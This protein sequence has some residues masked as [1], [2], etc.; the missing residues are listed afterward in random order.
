[1]LRQDEWPSLRELLE[2]AL[3]G[4]RAHIGGLL[5]LLACFWQT[6]LGFVLF[7]P[8]VRSARH[9][10]RELFPVNSRRR[11]RDPEIERIQ[12]GR[13]WSAAISSFLIL[14]AYGTAEDWQQAQ[15]QFGLRLLITPW[16]LLL[17][18]PAVVGLLFRLA[19]PAN[20][21]AM[22]AGL[23]R[24][25]R[26]VLWYFG[27]IGFAAILMWPLTLLMGSF[28]EGTEQVP[29]L[30]LAIVLMLAML[31]GLLFLA[32]SSRTAVRTA[33]STADM[34]DMVPAVLTCALVWEFAAIS[35][36]VGGLPPG[37]PLIQVCALIGGPVSVS[38]VAWWEISRLRTLHG[39]TL[40]A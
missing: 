35:L 6:V 5:L 11:I 16:L 32:F 12:K 29:H 13:A 7:Y 37:P 36:L 9:K 33:F 24:A 26:S 15:E 10:A 17:S 28:E 21:A 23:R 40:R 8:L 34:H 30:L 20:K 18:A 31:W 25:V 4:R 19:S 22:R 38:A 39:V 14:A 2:H 3:R 27:A 1:M